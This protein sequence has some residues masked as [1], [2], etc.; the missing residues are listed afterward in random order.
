MIAPHFIKS[1]GYLISTVSVALLGFV[2]WQSASQHPLLKLCL[3]LGMA[4][5]VLGMF[6]RW[7]SYALEEHRG[8]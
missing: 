8:R 6:L 3:I 2:S 7:L 4:A 5:S 1:C